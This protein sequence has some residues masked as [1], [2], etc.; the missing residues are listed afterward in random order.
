MKNNILKKAA[1]LALSSIMTAS[2][3]IQA[4]AFYNT[5]E[6]IKG[7]HSSHVTMIQDMVDL[8]CK[9]VIF[10]FNASFLKDEFQMQGV[11][12]LIDAY[13][14]ADLTVTIGVMN[15]F[16][17]NDALL[18]VDLSVSNLYQFNTLTDMGKQ[19][20]S[21]KTLRSSGL[22]MHLNPPQMSIRR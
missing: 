11:D 9:Q 21:R 20:T 13:N 1:A 16:Q 12:A 22:R 2:M 10:Q 18:P 8:G 19:R 17:P 6:S 4:L 14:A 5:P 15:D 3:S 7:I